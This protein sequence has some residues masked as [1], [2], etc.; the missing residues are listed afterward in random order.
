MAV[1]PVWTEFVRI[2]HLSGVVPMPRDL[3]PGTE[4]DALYV[5]QAM[6]WINPLHE[7]EASAALIAARLFAQRA[8]GVAARRP[9][10]HFMAAVGEPG[11]A[12]AS[13]CR[14]AQQCGTGG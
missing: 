3:K 10:P 7:A 5:A 11:R 14:A 13:A 1:L 9:D 6:P 12:G 8:G 4:D 2:A